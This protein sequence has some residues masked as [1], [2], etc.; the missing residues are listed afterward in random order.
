MPMPIGTVFVANV[1]S[2]GAEIVATSGWIPTVNETGAEVAAFPAWSTATA[3][4]VCV[5]FANP[6]RDSVC[7]NT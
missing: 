1:Q 2:G 3:V 4:S 6:P 5:P 7:E